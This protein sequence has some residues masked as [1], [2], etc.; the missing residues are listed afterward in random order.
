MPRIQISDEDV[1]NPTRLRQRM[2]FAYASLYDLLDKVST[3]QQSSTAQQPASV[4]AAPVAAAATGPQFTAADRALLDALAT[5]SVDTSIP[6]Q[7]AIVPTVSALSPVTNSTP[8]QLVNFG[9]TIYRFDGPTRTWIA[10][11]ASAAAHNV[12]SATHGDALAAVAVRGDLIAANATPAWS[13]LAKSTA[14]K[15]LRMNA[16][17]T[18]PEWGAVDDTMLS[19]NVA[20]ENVINVFSVEQQLGALTALTIG[21]AAAQNSAAIQFVWKNE[22]LDLA[23]VATKDTA[24][25]FL[26][27]SSLILSVWTLVDTTISGGGVTNFK[28]G[29]PTTVDRFGSANF[30]LGATNSQWQ[31]NHLKGNVA[32]E[33]TGWTQTGAGVVRITLD[34][35]PVAGKIRVVS[36]QLVA[37][38]PS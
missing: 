18:D 8:G 17:A 35:A 30:N 11:V 34:A 10:I 24:A 19:A 25:G 37:T 21:G 6:S 36:L 13:R 23:G 26:S 20:L 33:A 2:E 28:T 15:L 38:N 1:K 5:G 32:T 27:T 16:G 12:L 7:L 29:D 22:L 9:G 4:A 3:L 31:T 14:Y